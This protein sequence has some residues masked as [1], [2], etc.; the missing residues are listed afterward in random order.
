MPET[1]TATFEFVAERDGEPCHE[2]WLNKV[3]IPSVSEIIRPCTNYEG[4]K[5]QVMENA[6]EFGSDVDKACEYYDQDDLDESSLEDRVVRRLNGWIKF[7]KL[8]EFKPIDI[9]KPTF[10]YMNG[11]PYGMT[12]DRFGE[13]ILGLT[14][15]DIKN[16]AEVEAHHQLQLA[17]Y[18]DY[19][20]KG[21]KMP[22]KQLIVQL[23]DNDFYPEEFKGPKARQAKKIFSCLLPVAHW[24]IQN[25]VRL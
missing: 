1:A 22:I 6:R 5:K 18:E 2:Y 15:I 7:K 21:G 14:L 17:A 10:H 3:R 19:Y 20:S 23:M 16:C 8:Y 24:K 11:M 25:G 12:A 4:I 13:S 9:A